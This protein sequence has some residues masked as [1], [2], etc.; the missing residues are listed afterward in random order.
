[1]PNPELS[2]TEI[3]NLIAFLTWI[4]NVDTQGWP[5]PPILVSGNTFPGTG[6]RIANSDQDK[7]VAASDTDRAPEAAGEAL[8]SQVTPSCNSCHST[9]PGVNM[10]GP[11]LAGVA[12]RAKTMVQSSGYQGDATDVAGYLH[13]SIVKPGAYV[14]P[15]D[16]YSAEGR[17]FMPITYSDNLSDAQVDQLVAY[18][19]SLK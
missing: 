3:D 14:V 4:S 10:A 15:G 17:S 9:A 11:S 12:A 7:A 6:S 5:P 8:F 19:L 13:E 16:M 18:L 2:E 1:M